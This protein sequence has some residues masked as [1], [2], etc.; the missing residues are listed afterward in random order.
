MLLQLSAGS[1]HCWLL[2]DGGVMLIWAEVAH[3][4]VA[5]AQSAADRA[6]AAGQRAVSHVV[7]KQFMVASENE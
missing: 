4:V 6:R 1:R 3:R 7:P 5:L 2:S